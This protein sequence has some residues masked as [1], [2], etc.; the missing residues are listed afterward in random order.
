M[1]NIV[2]IRKMMISCSC[3][4]VKIYIKELNEKCCERML[5]LKVEATVISDNG[6]HF[7]D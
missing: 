1:F 2:L 5:N 4:I 3:G 6:I 7:S